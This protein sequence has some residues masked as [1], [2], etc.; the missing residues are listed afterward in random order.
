MT[1]KTYDFEPF[2]HRIGINEYQ[3]C[4]LNE[5]NRLCATTYRG[6]HAEQFAK[7]DLEREK[8]EIRKDYEERTNQE[9]SK[10]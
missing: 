9:Q 10:S 7:E 3:M 5:N 1:E 2:I 4:Y 6:R 8:E